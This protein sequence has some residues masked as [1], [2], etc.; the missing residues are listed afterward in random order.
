EGHPGVPRRELLGLMRWAAVALDG[1]YARHGL[2]HFGLSPRNL[3]VEG[4]RL[5]VAEFGLIPFLWLP[6][7]QSAAALNGRYAAPELHDRR[8]SRSADQY[9]LALIYAEMLTGVH[10]RR[11]ASGALRR[12]GGA[13]LTG[14]HK[15]ARLDLDLVPAR[16]REVILRALEADP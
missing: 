5:W 6:T 1:L 11:A 15:A 13:R 2:Q 3:L 12:P 14:A 16:D 8:P 10:P 9:S 7:G 4:D